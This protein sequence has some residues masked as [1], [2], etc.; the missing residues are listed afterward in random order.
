MVRVVLFY[1]V[2]GDC[3]HSAGEHVD[4]YDG[5]HLPE[6]RRDQERVA[7]TSEWTSLE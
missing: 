3:S 5:Q 4:R 2:H 7:E 6:D 1:S